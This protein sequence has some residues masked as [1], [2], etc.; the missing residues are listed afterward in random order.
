MY[1]YT[2][3]EGKQSQIVPV[4]FKFLFCRQPRLLRVSVR[5]VGR[6]G[7]A[8][9]L[10][11]FHSQHSVLV[12]A[13]FL[14]FQSFTLWVSSFTLNPQTFTLNK[15]WKLTCHC[16]KNTHPCNKQGFL[17]RC[18]TTICGISNGK[19]SFFQ[20]PRRQRDVI[21]PSQRTQRRWLLTLCHAIKDNSD[22]GGWKLRMK[23]NPCT[24]CF[25][26]F[27]SFKTNVLDQKQ[28]NPSNYLSQ[29]LWFHLRCGPIDP[30]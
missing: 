19:S 8:D 3:K 5:K 12:S 6:G 20:N 22:G 26:P 11:F 15:S 23:L 7:K 9:S 25:K 28:E 24:I 4:W 29:R 14:T 17:S 1:K 16:G 2:Q 10:C 21:F 18:C 27:V 13:P 30:I